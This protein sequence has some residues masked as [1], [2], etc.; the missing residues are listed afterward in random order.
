MK[1][2][3]LYYGLAIRRVPDS[4]EEMK[5]ALAGFYHKISTVKIHNTFT[6]QKEQI[7]GANGRRHKLRTRIISILCH[8]IKKLKNS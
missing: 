7:Y 3:S 5:E 4:V 1:D 6:V 2:L 8:L